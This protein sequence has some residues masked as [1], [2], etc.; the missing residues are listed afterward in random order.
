MSLK[1]R[2]TYLS[3]SC[4]ALKVDGIRSMLISD[5]S[6]NV[7]K[8]FGIAGSAIGSLTY[9]PYGSIAVEVGSAPKTLRYKGEF[10]DVLATGF[11]YSLISQGYSATLGRYMTEPYKFVGQLLGRAGCRIKSAKAWV[12]S[13]VCKCGDCIRCWHPSSWW[14][15]QCSCDRESQFDMNW[16]AENCN[17]C[18]LFQWAKEGNGSWEKDDG[19]GWPYP[20]DCS[21]KGGFIFCGSDDSPDSSGVIYGCNNS[22]YRELELISCIVCDNGPCQCYHWKIVHAVVPECQARCD[23]TNY[24]WL[25]G[26]EA[27]SWCRKS[28][29]EWK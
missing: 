24:G 13:K 25:S 17:E 9:F 14:S 6:S 5:P 4:I 3:S 11:G 26:A 15:G 1:S 2:A 10:G 23:E 22:S 19:E 8:S 16:A 28:R 27:I 21:S 7:I 20:V 29:K 18:R 12:D